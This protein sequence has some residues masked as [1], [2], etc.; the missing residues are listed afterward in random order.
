MAIRAS[1]LSLL[2]ALVLVAVS[3][4]AEDRVFEAHGAVLKLAVEAPG[5]D[6][7]LRGAVQI[8][9]EPGWKTYWIDPGEAGLAPRF[10]FSLSRNVAEPQVHFPVPEHFRDGDLVSNGYTSSVAF[11]FETT[12]AQPGDA[13]LELSLLIGLCREICVPVT[14]RLAVEAGGDASFEE[15]MMIDRAFLSLPSDNGTSLPG[16]WAGDRLI[17]ALPDGARPDALF[18]SGSGGWRFGPARRMPSPPGRFEVPVLQRGEEHA[19]WTA[20]L[21]GRHAER[22]RI[23]IPD[24]H[25]TLRSPNGEQEGPIQ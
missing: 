13:H 20:L 4:K 7:R 15:A 25:T 8:D 24:K 22:F 9:L 10:D 11:P 3:V 17:V 1:V 16:E 6:G 12:F 19:E 14:A 5:K 2:P 18:V 21:T 23:D